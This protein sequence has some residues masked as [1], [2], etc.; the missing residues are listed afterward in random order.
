MS[1]LIFV[2]CGSSCCTPAAHC[3]IERPVVCSVC[4]D[5]LKPNSRNARCNP[6]VLLKHKS[7][8]N[9]LFDCGK[10]FR[11]A[12]LRVLAARDDITAIDAVVLTHA[13]ADAAHGLDDL[14]EWVQ[15]SRELNTLKAIPIFVRDKDLE[16]IAS[17]FPYLVD[18]SKATGSGHVASLAF[19]A[20]DGTAP[21]DVLGVTIQPLI[22]DHGPPCQSVAF[23]I[24][25]FVYMSD[26]NAIP[27]AVWPLLECDGGLE[28]L[29][30][31]CTFVKRTISSHVNFPEALDILRKLKPRKTLFTGL[32]HEFDYHYFNALLHANLHRARGMIEAGIAEPPEQTVAIQGFDLRV[33]LPTLDIELPYDTQ[34]IKLHSC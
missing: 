17:S 30:L 23:R 19:H 1:E 21:I 6:S 24:G 16:S 14:R 27:P 7:G 18:A 13:H 2:G 33:S 3:L 34:S 12:V 5:A 28:L 9:I 25:D 4:I 29:I 32:T 20:F 15:G 22:V 11:S 10:T 26:V 8:V 31:D